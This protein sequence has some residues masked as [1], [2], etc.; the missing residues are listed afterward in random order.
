M[1]QRKRIGIAAGLVLTGSLL[2][3]GGWWRLIAKNSA[4]VAT[5]EALERIYARCTSEMVSNTCSVMNPSASPVAANERP[6]FVAG[7]GPI[8]ASDYAAL[9][10]AGDAMCSLVRDACAAD[11]GSPRCDTA[12]KLWPPTS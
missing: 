9:Y 8:A 3:A 5:T 4:S 12:K 1:N 2:F 10:A 6:I 11:W 7:V